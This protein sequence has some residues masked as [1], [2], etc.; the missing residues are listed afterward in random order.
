MP[1]T[2]CRPAKRDELPGPGAKYIEVAWNDYRSAVMPEDAT[3]EQLSGSRITFYAG[4]YSVMAVLENS[5]TSKPGD[6]PTSEE[7]AIIRAIEDELQAFIRTVK[8][9][10]A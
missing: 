3:E 6:E 7:L 1:S 10:K 4:A 2:P 8:K 9:G 5:M